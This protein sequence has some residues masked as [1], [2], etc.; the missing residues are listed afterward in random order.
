MLLLGRLDGQQFENAIAESGPQI[1][2]I[3][4]SQVMLLTSDH[5][6]DC[7]GDKYFQNFLFR[8]TILVHITC[9]C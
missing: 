2:E 4:I 7:L 5:F 8:W 3:L 9:V 6:V 1:S